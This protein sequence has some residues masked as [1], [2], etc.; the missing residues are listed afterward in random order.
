MLAQAGPPQVTAT[1]NVVVP[2]PAAAGPGTPRWRRLPAP[3]GLTALFGRLGMPLFWAALV[4]FILV[5]CASSIALAIS[6]RLFSQGT[7][8]FTLSYLGQAFSGSTAIAITNSLWVSAAAA[9]LG[10]AIGFPIAWLA[11]RTTLPGRRFVAGGMWLVLLLPSW[12]PALGWERLV[13][14]AG[15]MYRLGL[16]WPWVTHAV[17]GPAGVVFLLGLR[18]V[19]FTYLA[20]TAALA[21]LGQEFEDAARVHG[22]SRVATLRLIWP[23]LAPAIWSALAIGFAE[24]I[25]DF[26]VAATLAY[27]SNFSLATY[28]LFAAIGNFPPSFPLASAMG[29]LL[30]AAV[31][32][33]LALQARALRGRSYQMLSGRTRQA[34]RRQL[35]R[36][37][38]IAAAAGVGLFYL[39]ALGVPGFGAVSASLLGDFGGSYTLT[40][41]NYRALLHEAGQIGPLERS[42]IYAAVTSFI[43]VTGGFVAAW[44]LAQ[45]R[46]KSSRFLDF[47]LLAAIALPSV[48]FAAGYI[49]AYNLPFWSRLGINLYQTTTLLVIAYAASSLPTTARVLVGAVSQLQ[50]SLKDAAR[51]HGAGAVTA[52]A[53]GVLPV[54]S[55]PIVMAWLLVFC[56]VFL[57]LPISQL[58]YAPG[59]PPASIAIQSNLSNYHFGVGM[60]QAVLAVGIALA[61]VLI[62][63]GGYRLLAPAGWRRIGGASR[64]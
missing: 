63:L 52:W 59:S 55:R 1:R 44:L 54:V 46:A 45:R 7:Q 9:A 50:P 30:V 49:F 37:G 48:V 12:L 62:V 47:L 31:A 40:L 19:P 16:N 13:E 27:N 42:L 64:G 10:L 21:G 56:G 15:P 18:S 6:P 4:L 11:G 14:P 39:I 26:G 34:V 41:V 36:P 5:P 33:P 28:Q 29:T 43:T 53:R 22:A 32:I 58:L 8:W 61:A 38:A 20:V 60:A 17:M 51:T 24:S 23:M 35:S 57:E 3:R 25:S 2:G